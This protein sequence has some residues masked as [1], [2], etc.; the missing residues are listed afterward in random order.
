MGEE[1]SRSCLRFESWG[2]Y[3]DGKNP[4]YDL[5][6]DYCTWFTKKC[7]IIDFL[8]SSRNVWEIAH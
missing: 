2:Y 4:D 3:V 8:N 1:A 7:S 5:H 6:C